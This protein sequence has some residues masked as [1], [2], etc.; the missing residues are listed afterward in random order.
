MIRYLNGMRVVE[1]LTL[2][3]YKLMIKRDPKFIKKPRLRKR[4][5]TNP[6]RTVSVP[7]KRVLID[8]VANC[9]YM[10]PVVAKALLNEMEYSERFRLNQRYGFMNPH[11]ILAKGL[12]P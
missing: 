10:H 4:I 3:D 12:C 1:S 2:V 5:K 6:K 9:I 11:N 8:E 7:S